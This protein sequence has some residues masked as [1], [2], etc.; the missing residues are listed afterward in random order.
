M[1]TRTNPPLNTSEDQDF[2][3]GWSLAGRKVGPASGE[4]ALAPDAFHICKTVA[5]LTAM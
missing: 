4:V 3:P 5:Q 1:V 2:H